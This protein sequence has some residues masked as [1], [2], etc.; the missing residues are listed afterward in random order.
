MA[1][2]VSFKLEGVDDLKRALAEVSADI[3]KKSVRSALRSAGR[4]I[5]VSARAKAPVL[6]TPAPHR[7]PGTV[8]KSIVVRAS[9]FARR[10][11]DEGI[12]INVRGIR[13]K[14]RVA[15]L[16]AAGAKNPN[17]PFYW[18]FLELGTKKMAARPFLRPAAEQAGNA[19]IQTFMQSIVP[20]IE[21]HNRRKP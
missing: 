3:R 10:A 1:D 4:V 9:K 15:R 11:G 13:G 18:R 14:A 7:K 5:Q 16:G 12:Y 8:K 21:K 20:Q 19:A 2:G 17:D 6:T